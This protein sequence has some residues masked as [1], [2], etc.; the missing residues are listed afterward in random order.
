MFVEGKYGT[1]STNRL[2][3]RELD[4]FIENA[5]A[6]VKMLGED[7]CRRLPDPERM[8][9]DAR[10]GLELGLYDTSYSPDDTDTRL[11]RA[12]QLAASSD[13]SPF[14]TDSF[15][16][17]SEECEYTVPEP[18]VHVFLILPHS[19]VLLQRLILMYFTKN[20]I[21]VRISHKDNTVFPFSISRRIK[22]FI[23]VNF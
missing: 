10:T 14:D 11:A 8:E 2:D 21:F 13:K 17:I 12:A 5:I 22:H 15:E 18:P 7:E 1:F 9:K 3:E 20:T 16:I 4:S 6:M 23:G 19:G